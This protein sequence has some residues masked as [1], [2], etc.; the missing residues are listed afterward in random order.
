MKLKTVQFVNPVSFG[1][2]LVSASM[3]PVGDRP[4]QIGT[5]IEADE[6]MRF[7]ALTRV[8]NGIQQTKVVP[9]TNIAAFEPLEEAKPVPAAGVK[10]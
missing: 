5:I 6:K 2:T 9:M 1:G 10:K 7:V 3:N 8:V 4:G